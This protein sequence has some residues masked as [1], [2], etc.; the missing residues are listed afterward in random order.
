M[1]ILLVSV[2]FIS[3]HTFHRK[4]LGLAYLHAHALADEALRGRVGITHRFFDL[5]SSSPSDIAE[6]ILDAS[7]DLV[8]FGCFVWNTPHV[9]ETAA[10]L[11]A[12]NPSIRIVLGGP[13]VDH[14]YLAVLKKNPA[15]DFVSVG[16]GEDNF[17]ELLHA[18]LE[19]QSP[20]AVPGMACRGPEGPAL[21]HR[22]SP[23]KDLDRFESPFLTGV[24]EVDAR[25][26]GA[27]FQTS[28]GCPFRCAY[29]AWGRRRPYGEFS[30]DRVK[31]ELELF[32]AQGARSLFCAD[33]IFNLN[34]K[35]AVKILNA[36]VDCGLEAALW[37]ETYPDL[38]DESFVN[39]VGKCATSYLGLGIQTTH[40]PA[41]ESINR[42]WEPAKTEAVLNRLALND[43]CLAG[44]EVIMGLPGDNL[45]SFKDTLSWVY[46]K[47]ANTV[48]AFTLQVVPNT[49]LFEEKER[50][51]IEVEGPGGFHQ[52][53]SNNTFSAE[54]IRVGKT[55]RNW[56]R[57][58]Q[59][60][61]YRLVH[62]T[63]LAGGE[64]IH[65]WTLFADKA[66]LEER[67][68]EFQKH[69]TERTLLA[70]LVDVFEAFC[71]RVLSD[72]DLPDLSS[73]LREL[74]RYYLARRWATREAAGFFEALD[75]HGITTD[76]KYNRIV[77]QDSLGSKIRPEGGF[78]ER[79]EFDMGSLWRHTSLESLMGVPPEPHTYY[80]FTSEWGSAVAMEI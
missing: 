75:V 76:S 2:S 11:K 80:F 18:L 59:Q 37:L 53:L 7:P 9:L 14:D 1:N 10:L 31:A 50:F 55:M 12:K 58:M 22:R 28:R 41:M 62:A 77:T 27:F 16:E 32:Q 5:A 25:T 49:P 21:L 54:E 61:F 71:A 56:N 48:Y 30:L 67:A 64:L 57:I 63:G 74:L 45:Q 4:F 19:G 35:R 73:R 79:F 40:P 43:N 52:I 47:R 60:V 34:N 33:S 51:G 23:A 72:A 17:R 44:F 20:G 70:R 24:I 78:E 3:P 15:V 6:A 46:R 65:Q 26:G 36:A 29:C 13:E 42:K 66:G 69:R 8:G 68:G 39:A 38:L